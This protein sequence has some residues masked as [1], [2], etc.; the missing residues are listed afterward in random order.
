MTLTVLHLIPSLAGGG[1]ERQ[2]SLLAPA[3]AQSG[4]EV[5]LAYGQGGPNLA[6]LE[7]TEVHLHPLAATG[8]HDPKLAW[9]I[10]SLVRRLRPDVVQTWL[11]QMDVLG[12][13]AALLNRVP[14]ILSERAS[15]MAYEPGLKNSLRLWMGQRAARVV[16]NSTGGA[17]YWRRHI[18]PE[19]LAVVR[20]CITPSEP[21]AV[22]PS[23]PGVEVRPGQPIILFAGRLCTQKNVLRLVD[24]LAVVMQQRH[25]ALALLFGEGPDRASIVGRI[26]EHGLERSVIL[27]GFTT[28]LA[29]WMKRASVCV[30]PSLFEGHPNVVIEAAAAGCPLVI[31]DIKSHREFFDSSC[32]LLV[33]PESPALIAQAIVQTL[34]DTRAAQERAANAMSVVSQFDLTKMALAYRS[35]Y[36]ELATAWRGAMSTTPSP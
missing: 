25:D 36:A 27:N 23:A 10:H 21:Q 9:R 1:A 4:V 2:L 8:N 6:R 33:P 11:L 29:R 22:P 31:S 3:L 17:E 26:R 30:L 35:I 15:K 24:A 12:G 16:A 5:H 19:R 7:N 34:S 14:F 28:D 20:N 18:G 13:A 32:A